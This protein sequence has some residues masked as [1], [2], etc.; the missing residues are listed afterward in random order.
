MSALRYPRQALLPDVLRVT[1]GLALTIGPLCLVDTAGPVAL[2]L[3][4]AAALFLWFGARLLLQ[5]SARVELDPAGIRLRRLGERRIAWS[6]LDLMRL[7]F[8][9]PRRGLGESW[10]ELTLGGKGLRIRLESGLEGF[11]QGARTAHRAAL[12]NALPLDSATAANLKN[13]ALESRPH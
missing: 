10:R 12:E 11:D 13:F 7:A 6:D 5:A 9:A 4:A 3:A 8:Y 2:V 1:A